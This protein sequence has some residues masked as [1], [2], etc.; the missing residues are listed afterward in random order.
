MKHFLLI[1]VAT[2][3]L[4]GCKKEMADTNDLYLENVKMNLADSLS[5]SHFEALDFS[6]SLKST[7]DSVSLYVLRV[8]FK[9]KSVSEDF[10]VVK[11]TKEGKVKEG[12]IVHHE[13][14]VTHYLEGAVN[15]KRWDGNITMLSLSGQVKLASPIVNGYITL[16]HSNINTR[17]SSLAPEHILPEVIIVSTIHSGGISWSSWMMVQSFFLDYG[18]GGSWGGYYGSMYDSYGGPGGGG[19]SGGG[20]STGGGPTNDPP[21]LI[22]VEYFDEHDAID[23]EKY[24]KCF[25]SIPDAGATCSIEIFTDIPVDSDPNK[26]FDIGTRSPGHTFIQI[27]KSNGA[28]STVQNIG[29]YPKTGFK[30]VLTNAPIDGK[31]VDDGTHEYNASLFKSLT[32]EALA[33]TLIKIQN[34]AGFI[35]YDVDN[36]NC[37]DF[38]LDVFNK[39]GFN[40]SIPLYDIPGNYPSTGT[41]MPVGIYNRLQQLKNENGPQ[42]A[43]INMGFQ[44]GYTANSVGPCN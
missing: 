9:G 20:G 44:K 35:K 16:L 6:N 4:L 22:D 2:L 34:L 3:T 31:F 37:T 1:A 8:P 40:L 25:T 12:S 43:N 24:I 39:T 17:T 19:S 27:K 28:Q 38:A 15:R 5:A 32:P 14:K 23:I 11:T 7:V 41:R 21:I 26:I 42:S 10:V 29:F 30:N 33:S 13:G 18:I 36:Y